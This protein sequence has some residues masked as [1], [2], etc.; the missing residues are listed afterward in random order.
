M[1]QVTTTSVEYLSFLSP[2]TIAL[3][4]YGH[5]YQPWLWRPGHMCRAWRLGTARRGRLATVFNT[6]GSI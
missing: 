2:D 3:C 1:K 5:G 4:P 6:S